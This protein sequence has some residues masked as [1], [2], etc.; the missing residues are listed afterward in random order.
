MKKYKEFAFGW[1]IMAI[2]VPL[3]LLIIFLYAFQI[4]DRPLPTDVFIAVLA[5]LLLVLFLFYGLTTE[6]TNDYVLVSFGA[7]LIRKKI[8]VKRIVKVIIVT[9][10]WYY[11][12]GIRYIPNGMLYNISGTDGIEL[13]FNDSDRIVRIG[14]PNP[15][16]LKRE[17]EKRLA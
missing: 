2:I 3:H 10:P 13:R 8:N 17:I 6:V 1:L 11:G 4:G 7:G 9:N 14:S 15:V 16:E 12:W 5:L